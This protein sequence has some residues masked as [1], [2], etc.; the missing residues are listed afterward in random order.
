V[1]VI[2]SKLY[3]GTIRI[4]DVGGLFKRNERLYVGSRDCSHLAENMSWQV[5]ALAHALAAAKVEPVPRI[6][7]VLCFV[8]GER[9]LLFPPEAYRGVRLEGTRSI[10]KLIMR[11]QVLDTAAID[12]LTRRLAIA[13][14]PR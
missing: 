1:F 7:P 14:P 13:L 8:S 5:D 2:D 11:E 10:K 3:Q 4:R 12:S 9:P 6:T